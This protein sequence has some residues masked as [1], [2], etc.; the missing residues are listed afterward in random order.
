[1]LK[2]YGHVPQIME[3]CGTGGGPGQLSSQS[4]NSVPLLPKQTWKIFLEGR[5]PIGA[6]STLKA[7]SNHQST[8]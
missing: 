8:S 6:P 7:S 2:E 4:D 5:G 3:E 1:M